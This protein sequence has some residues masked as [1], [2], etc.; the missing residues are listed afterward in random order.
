MARNKIGFHFGSNSYAIGYGSYIRA[1]D[2]AGIPAAVMSVGGEGLGD[3]VQVWDE[4]STVEHVAIVR[5]LS[6]NDVPVYKL[7]PKVA[8]QEWLDR[9][10]PTIGNDVK[11]YH[12][13]VITLH[14]NEVDKEK[15][16]WLAKFYE[17]LH[18][19]LL[20]RMGWESHRICCFNFSTGEPEPEQWESIAWFLELA[21]NNPDKWVIG[22]HEYS[23]DENN[24][25]NGNGS[26]VGRF[27]EIYKITDEYQIPRPHVAI[28]EFGWRDTV[29]PETQKA[30][31][32]ID[33]VASRYC[34]YQTVISAGVWTLQD[35]Q[36]SNI[37]HKVQ[38]LIEPIKLLTL[39]KDYSCCNEPPDPTNP[40]PSV[41]PK[42]VIAKKPQPNEMTL[43]ENQLVGEWAFRQYGR[44][45]THSH[46]DMLRML[47][48]GNKQS[49][50]VVWYPNRPSQMYAIE[51]LTKN[52]FSYIVKT[53]DEP[54]S[55]L[56]G[57][58]LGRL[59]NRPYVLT[60]KFNDQRDYYPNF[61]HEGIDLSTGVFDSEILAVYDGVVTFSMDT[62]KGY[63]N[64]VVIK[65]TNNNGTFFTWYAHMNQRRVRAGDIVKQG[66]VIGT[67]GDSGRAFGA[68]THFTLQ[69]PNFGEDGYVISDIVDPTQYL[70]FDS[71]LPLSHPKIDMGVYFLPKNGGS[72]SSIYILKNNWGQNDERVQLQAS[73]SRSF[74]VK[75]EQYEERIVSNDRIFYVKDTSP[76]NNRY[77]TIESDT[78]WMPRYWSEG[79][80]FTRIEWLRWY[81]K[82][83]CHFIAEYGS[84]TD[85][86]FAKFHPTWESK[87]GIHLENVI[88]LEWWVGAMIDERYFY[89]PN[90]GLV[91]WKKHSG[92]ESWIN[93][94]IPRGSQSNNVREI[95]CF[96]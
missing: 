18:P 8:V 34:D 57:I 64:Y 43:E 89:A 76:G 53:D 48:G 44:T 69:V 84:T 96:S 79:D 38:S 80:N 50:A 39:S 46:D 71:E 26:L 95:G 35:W 7:E 54:V 93:E 1:L 28:T 75:N 10:V 13:R 90:L 2:E 87:G 27:K 36:G 83:D 9:Y 14:G 16:Q 91:A 24:I 78:G 6:H 56:L 86:V 68:H 23:L 4:G 33:S 3:I 42:V 22:V 66:H 92:E 72:H 52:G 29:I 74:V 70:P 60:S 45:T 77:F 31:A 20:E 94:L 17:E 5:C 62:D 63:G 65:H 32:D 15:I 59:F 85:L 49:Y 88:E 58:K 55:P 41:L 40:P 25:W 82:D 67:M 61:L 37:N 11:K 30:M 73:G 81:N 21:G 47:S 12:D 51:Q 19:A